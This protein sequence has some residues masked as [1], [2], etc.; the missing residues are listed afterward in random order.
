MMSLREEK[1][2]DKIIK[3]KFIWVKTKNK[4]LLVIEKHIEQRGKQNVC[5]EDLM[6]EISDFCK[7]SQD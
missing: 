1:I 5:G 3:E 6:C 4:M 2:S 7:L